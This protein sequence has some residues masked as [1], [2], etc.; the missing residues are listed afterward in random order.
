MEN[1]DKLLETDIA[2]VAAKAGVSPKGSNN[3]STPDLGGGL[4]FEF[5]TKDPAVSVAETHFP[6]KPAP[7][8][9]SRQADVKKSEETKSGSAQIER[10]TEFL[11]PDKDAISTDLTP[12]KAE[13]RDLTSGIHKTYVPRFT[14]V[15]E[16][17][18]MKDD[19]RPRPKAPEVEEHT[20]VTK[21]E[22]EAEKVAPPQPITEEL[23]PTAELE[24][25]T[26][27]VIVTMDK[28]VAD[29]DSETL[30]VYKFKD[31]LTEEKGPTPDEEEEAL[32]R[33]LKSLG[34]NI[35]E[36]KPEEP[37]PEEVEEEKEEKPSEY[38]MPDPDGEEI[39]VRDFGAKKPFSQVDPEG[40]S[41]ATPEQ[42]KKLAT[43]FTHQTQRDGFKDKFLDGLMSLKIRLA[44]ALL[45]FVGIVGFELLA[46]IGKISYTVFELSYHTGALAAIDLLIITC[47]YLFA[48]PETVRAIRLLIGGRPTPELSLTVGYLFS[49]AY[50]LVTSSGVYQNYPL[51]GS[52][53][54]VFVLI[55][56]LSAYC[57]LSADFTAF[58]LIS[59]SK[60]KRI[61]DKK[62]TRELPEEN[63]ALDGL[64]DE[65]SSRTARVFRTGFITD[66]FKKTRHTAENSRHTA[67]I[68]LVAL[69]AA[70]VS[71]VVAFFVGGG[72]TVF[73]DGLLSGT[74]S[75]ALVFNLGMPAFAILSHKLAYRDAQT[76]AG[77]EDST[78]V[79]EGSYLAFSEVDVIAFEDSEIFGP[80][81]VALK[82]FMLYGDS[83]NME[84]AMRQMCAL[85]GVVGGPLHYIFSNSLD[86]RMRITPALSPKIEEDGLSGDVGGRRISA[87]TEEYM[88]RHG[89]AIPEG[90]SR[91]EGGIDT[92]KIMYASEDGEVFAKFYIRYSFSEEFTM[93][94]PTLKEEGIVPLI[95]TGDP[96]VSNDLLKMLSA[97]A[98]CMRV[99]K[100]L[101]PVP[102]DDKLYSRVSA[103]VVTYGDKINAIDVLLLTKKY[104]RFLRAV[105]RAELVAMG[106]G[107]LA[108]V[109]LLLVGVGVPACFLALWQLV[110]SVILRGATSHKLGSECAREKK[111]D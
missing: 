57:K 41:E 80:D 44:V 8:E 59:R 94:L 28:P 95:Y 26:E 58:K 3:G 60:E 27:G 77:A 83:E 63:M 65:Y 90:A 72:L 61:L 76:S 91:A 36:E 31:G 40:V 53:F 102:E 29:E 12:P 24:E 84:Q 16:T 88:R 108:A 111:E 45:F 78:V 23:D 15:S 93:L 20:V 13:D 19:P 5:D 54:A 48:L 79:G 37:E 92:T 81:D 71:A 30:N 97:G 99:V 103:G 64:I 85:F 98:D 67:L 82:R 39:S 105:S 69:G 87:G 52:L 25:S 46:I 17:Y 107:T 56:I 4:V 7:E 10:R 70:I 11:I 89:V 51:F 38:K 43:E 74:A 47:M 66:F 50:L 104:K 22:P 101:T 96:N 14:D 2:S 9:K 35:P 1:K 34:R 6:P 75:L 18:R 100:R 21:L 42:P 68:L 32:R 110:L 73:A 55:T 62:M 33:L 86:N 49:A 109:V 106:V